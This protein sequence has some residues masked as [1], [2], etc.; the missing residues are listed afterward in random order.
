M[1]GRKVGQVVGTAARRFRVLALV[2]T[3]GPDQGYRDGE[4]HGRSSPWKKEGEGKKT[5]TVGALGF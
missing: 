3:V 5:A 1:W 2:E 4:L